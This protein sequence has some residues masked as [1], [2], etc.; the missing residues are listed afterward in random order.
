MV[1]RYFTLLADITVMTLEGD[2]P[3]YVDK[4]GKAKPVSHRQ[5]IIQRTTDAS[6]SVLGMAGMVS[7]AAIRMAVDKIEAGGVVELDEDDWKR[8]VEAVEKPKVL[9]TSTGQLI[10]AGY[11][12]VA[13]PQVLPFAR[14]IKDASLEDPRKKEMGSGEN[15]TSE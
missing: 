11:D 10:E 15:A 4:D 12:G 1:R 9:V 6:F 7:A 2:K 3:Y 5:F 13:G 14:A 8:L